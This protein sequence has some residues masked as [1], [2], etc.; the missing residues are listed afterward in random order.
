MDIVVCLKQVPHPDYFPK[1]RLDPK[2]NRARREG[3]PTI[4]NP[5][6]RNAIEA[7]LQL[8]ERFHGRVTALTMGPPEAREALEEALAMGA[9]EAIL[10]TD[11]A[12]GGADTLATALTLAT[13][14]RKYCSFELILCGSETI[15][16]GTSQVGPQLAELLDL[17]H[18][19]NV[20]LIEFTNEKLMQ[21]ERSLG[22]GYMKVRATLPALIT[23][24]REINQARLPT[25]AG[26]MEV[27]NK[28]LTTYRLTDL[29]L[30][31]EQV[32]LL[33]SPSQVA[34]LVESKQKRR[35]EILQGRP[36]QMVKEAIAG[37][38][39]LHIV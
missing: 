4:I 32:G 26:I 21:V 31:P 20:R 27:A 22:N 1:I 13:V 17:P 8:R 29:E 12:F 2:T 33:G 7:G 6:D 38:R 23:V 28:K 15:D 30:S 36:E 19:T 39:A 18:V 3:I 14:I 10:L 16:S 5:V 35:N 25:V 24:N 11:I 9:D 37:L 34:E